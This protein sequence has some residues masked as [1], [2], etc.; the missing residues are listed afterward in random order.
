[1][2]REGERERGEGEKKLDRRTRNSF[3]PD[4]FPFDLSANGPEQF[5]LCFTMSNESDFQR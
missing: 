2:E 5:D 3:E 1:M 4:A